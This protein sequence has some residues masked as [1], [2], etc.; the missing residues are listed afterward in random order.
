VEIMEFPHLSNR[1]F[2]SAVPKVVINEE[3]DF[4]GALPEKSYLDKI[5]DADGAAKKS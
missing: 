1:Y 2:V 3:V 4:E 5:M